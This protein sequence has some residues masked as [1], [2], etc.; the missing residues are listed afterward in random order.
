M[1]LPSG[2]CVAGGGLLPGR[3]AGERLP[4]VRGENKAETAEQLPFRIKSLMKGEETNEK[5]AQKIA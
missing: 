4:G 3:E 1:G 2:A 5:N